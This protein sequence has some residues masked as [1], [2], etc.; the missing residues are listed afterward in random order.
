MIKFLDLQ[1]VNRQYAAEL[2]T[3]AAEVIDSGWYLRGERTDKF[4]RELADYQ[5]ASHVVGVGNG[6]DALRL[7]FK[8]YLALGIMQEGDEIIVPAHTFIASILAITENR[9][10]PIFVDIDPKTWNLDL[11]LLEE[12][13]TS[14]TKGIL[15]V[16]LYGRICWDN[17]LSILAEKHNLKFV[18]DNAQAIGAEWQGVKSG[19]LGDAAGFSFYPGKILGA[20]GDAGAV[21]TNDAALAEI[22]RELANYGSTEKYIY[23]LQG[24]NSRMDEIQAAF[25]SVKLRHLDQEI[26]VRRKIACYY[27][28]Q[29]SNPEITLAE[30]PQPLGNPS[31]VWHLFC[32]LCGK[33]DLFQEYL[34]KHQIETVIHYP[35]PPYLQKA[36]SIYD[37]LQFPQTEKIS[38]EVISLPISSALTE[39]EIKAVVGIINGFRS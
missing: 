38:R 15:L 11:S 3:A 35:K 20:L 2:K 7:I 9:L 4:E 28:D 5:R 25:L 17:K 6:S 33:R 36:Y 24:I 27:L 13:I 37:Q 31:H 29:I 32:I 12:H 34:C 22:I 8:G 14:R 39:K 10:K 23:N 18:E 21:V 30:F 19:S 1:K 16:H 26:T